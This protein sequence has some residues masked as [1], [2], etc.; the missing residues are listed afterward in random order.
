VTGGLRVESGGLRVE[1]KR[2]AGEAQRKQGHAKEVREKKAA[3]SVPIF[4][5]RFRDI[6]GR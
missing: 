1:R 4:V 3:V 5:I 2:C 6:D